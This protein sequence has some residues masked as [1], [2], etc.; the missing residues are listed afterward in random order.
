MFLNVARDLV[1]N[2]LS[3]QNNKPLMTARKIAI[4]SLKLK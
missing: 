3:K 4:I 2:V 1:E